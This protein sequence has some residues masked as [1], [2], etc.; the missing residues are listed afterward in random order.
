MSDN[1][2]DPKLQKVLKD[3]PEFVDTANAAS[4][5][6]LKAIVLRSEQ[7]ISETEKAKQED[8][9]LAAK[10]EEAKEMT[11]PYRETLKYLNA[12]IRYSIHLLQEKGENLE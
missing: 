12:K 6:E 11:A 2:L 9:K 10:I 1:V 8:E 3:M 4:A 5:E 7:H